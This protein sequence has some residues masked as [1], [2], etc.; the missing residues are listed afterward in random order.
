MKLFADSACD[1]P[2]DFFD[3]CQITLIPLHVHL[4][5]ED[6]EDMKGINPKKV[7]EAIRQGGMPKTSQASPLL[8]EK[9]FT[10]LAESGEPGIY[11]AFSSALSGTYQTAVM[12]RD[13]VKETHP[14]LDLTI[15]DT[16]AASLGYGL[17][18]MSAAECLQKGWLKKDIVADI[19]FHCQHMEHIFTVEDLGHLAKGGRLSNSAAWIGGLLNIKPILHVEEGRLVPLEKV[20]GRKK[21]LNRMLDIMEERGKHLN[22]QR[23]A[24]SH[25]DDSES[26][27]LLKK[28]IAERFHSQEIYTHIIGSTIASHAGPGTV[29]LFFLNETQLSD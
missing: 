10:E 5:G 19:Q 15:I 24:I 29:A 6:F 4:N 27:E 9:L 21:A 28:M 13:Q 7:Y 17:I 11:P 23:V 3:S 22:V 18:V 1:L 26:A 16:K 8:L 25:G 20:R 12:V 2:L 14:T